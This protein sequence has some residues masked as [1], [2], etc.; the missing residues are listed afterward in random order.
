MVTAKNTIGC[1][2]AD[3]RRTTHTAILIAAVF[4]FCSGCETSLDAQSDVRF[5]DKKFATDYELCEEIAQYEVEQQY[6]NAVS[7]GGS[8]LGFFLGNAI[9]GNT[10]ANATSLMLKD[11]MK[12]RGHD[13]PSK[14][15]PNSRPIRESAEK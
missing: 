8:L 12:Q 15:E 11:C 6:P 2:F 4:T 7:G 3:Q 9:H 1:N 13:M 10:I 5:A 14:G